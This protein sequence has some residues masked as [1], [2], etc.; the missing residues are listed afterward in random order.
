MLSASGKKIDKPQYSV[1][2]VS[3]DGIF[4]ASNAVWDDTRTSFTIPDVTPGTYRL[5]FSPPAP[6][7][8]KSATLGGRDIAGSDVTI[9]TG[10]GSI[11]IVLSDDGG[12][13]E[14]DVSNDDG[15][16]SAWIFVERDGAPSR[17]TRAD[18]NGHFKID[19][20]PPGDY[21]VYAWDDNTK[22][23]YANPEWMQRNGKGV[24]VTVEPGQTA[25]V[26]LVRQIAPNE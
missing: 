9:G 22:V 20:V 1:L 23:E 13:V 19:A 7:Y 11:E 2:L 4:G 14:G 17:N 25:Q 12:K 15:P 18:P 26:K 3:P 24:A 21:K 16:V 8:L 6:F 10:S 5:T